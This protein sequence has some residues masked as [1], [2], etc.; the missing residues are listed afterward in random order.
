MRHPLPPKIPRPT[1]AFMIFANE[2]RK[3]M[4]QKFPQESNKDISKRLGITWKT[5]DLPE[6]KKYFE[7]AKAVDAEHKKKPPF[8]DNG[9]YN[10]DYYGHPYQNYYTNAS[11]YPHQWPNSASFS[12][13]VYNPKE[14]RIRKAMR[15]A[16]REQT[17]GAAPMSSPRGGRRSQSWTT[18][19]E[20][21]MMMHNAMAELQQHQAHMWHQYQEPI[22]PCGESPYLLEAYQN[23]YQDAGSNNILPHKKC[24]TQI[25]SIPNNRKSDEVTTIKSNSEN[26]AKQEKI[27]ETKRDNAQILTDTGNIHRTESF[28]NACEETIIVQN[29]FDRDDDMKLKKNLLPL[30]KKNIAKQPTKALPDFN[31]AFGS[32]ERGRFQS[33]PDPRLAPNKSYLDYI[34]FNDTNKFYDYQA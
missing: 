28:L 32:T 31:E 30:I 16:S 18:N 25:N 7:L 29:P 27:D 17:L 9:F 2:N 15:E 33:P 6:K 21:H 23:L 1:N 19:P 3:Q 5:L 22:R 10:R 8:Y 20:E 14:A 34:F 24:K 26:G 13:Y 4:A 12:D 11:Y